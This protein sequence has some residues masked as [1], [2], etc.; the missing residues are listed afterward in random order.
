[1]SPRA[2]FARVMSRMTT[3]IASAP[4]TPA[5]TE[6][7]RNVTIKCTGFIAASLFSGWVWAARHE[8]A[9]VSHSLQLNLFTFVGC[10]T[11]FARIFPPG[12]DKTAPPRQKFFP[13]GPENRD[14]PHHQK[15]L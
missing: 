7:P 5:A 14:A 15:G 1:M 10:A 12:L 8:P 11:A 4:S 9:T 3:A 13:Y 2:Q 6:K